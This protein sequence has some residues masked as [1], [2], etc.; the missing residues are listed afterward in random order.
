[1]SYTEIRQ[2]NNISSVYVLYLGSLHEHDQ[3]ST[4]PCRFPYLFISPPPLFLSPLC[5]A[6]PS[7][8]PPAPVA[9]CQLSLSPTFTFYEG[10]AMASASTLSCVINTG[11]SGG[12]LAPLQNQADACS[13]SPLCI[14]ISYGINGA[15]LLAA[16]PSPDG[17]SEPLTS[18]GNSDDPCFGVYILS[19]CNLDQCIL[20][21]SVSSECLPVY[22]DSARLRFGFRLKSSLLSVSPC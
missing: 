3:P 4:V 14:A 10:T 16:S 9:T 2:L 1:M 19:E 7:Y 15:C 18:T 8:P 21:P 22:Y 20:K 12:G 13:Q 11:G 6:V 5:N 17:S